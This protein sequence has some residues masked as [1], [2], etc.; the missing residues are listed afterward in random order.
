MVII[1]II[2]YYYFYNYHYHYYLSI[3]T[4]VK[5]FSVR[6]RTKWFWV[7]VQL[8]SLLLMFEQWVLENRYRNQIYLTSAEA[9]NF[10]YL[11]LNGNISPENMGMDMMV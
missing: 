11:V 6:L 8:Q 5:W 3:M 1:I 9:K 7:R 10:K 4:K 2:I